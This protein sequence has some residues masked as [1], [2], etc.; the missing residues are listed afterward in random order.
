MTAQETTVAAAAVR[1]GAPAATDAALV[2]AKAAALARAGAHGLPVLPGFVLPTPVVDVLDE[3]PGVIDTA[4][5]RAAWAG[6]SRDGERPLVVRSSSTV[7]DLAGGSMAG[8]FVSV[9]DVRGWEAFVRAVHEVARSRAL[10]G[11]TGGAG[12][13]L[14]V[15]VQPL[16][17]ARVGGVLFGADPVTGRTDRIVVAAVRGQPEPL[18]SGEVD[19]SRL[20]LDLDGRVLSCRS[21]DHGP[22]RREV[23]A[24]RLAALARDTAALYAGPQDVEWAVGSDGRLWLLQSRPVTVALA[25][26]PTGPVLGTG[27][28]AE[29]FPA[30]LTRLEQELWV[31][32]L[33]RAV[34]EAV[35]LAGVAPPAAVA[36]SPA[37][38]CVDGQVAVDLELLGDVRPPSGPAR[39]LDPRPAVRRL[40]AAWRV[41]RLRGALPA[42]G[43]DLVQRVDA[44]LGDVPPL[45]GL[46]DRRLLGLLTRTGE[47]LHSVQAHEMLVGLIVDPGAPRR[48]AASVALR[49]LA[50]ARADGLADPEI[51][52]RHPVVLGLTAP[53]VAA[54][55]AL[56][57]TRARRDA[58]PR[59]ADEPT[60]EP[61]AD[62]QGDAATVRE[63]LRLRARWLHEL[64]ARAAWLLGSR[65]AGRGLLPAPD[66]VRHVGFDDLAR[67]VDGH[68]VALPSYDEGT[69]PAPPPTLPVRFRL[70]DRG[71]PVAVPTGDGDAAEAG[72][73][74]GGGTG[75]GTV[76]DPASLRDGTGPAD[77]VLVVRTLDP[78]LA[79]LLPGLRGLVAE[80]GSVLS[81]L[82]VL[83]R[84]EGVPT[85]VGVPDAAARL[86]PG[87]RVRVDGGSG[88]VTVVERTEEDL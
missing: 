55:P 62:P 22:G 50:T 21:G 84:E 13:P 23:P 24:R 20:E 70:T 85:A 11:D 48:T 39:R 88:R 34:R 87:T 5:V 76:V 12:A 28:V 51:V 83:A 16:L 17:D 37:V 1:L 8:R 75:E 60:P 32:P 56:P 68:R 18:V 73:G 7:E 4:E 64:G 35:A 9:V 45:E 26:T 38:V 40:S 82:A 66:A 57:P 74:A 10:V 25:G 31:P 49:V 81:H 19:G 41:G 36:A 27:P 29:T 3:R 33:R 72:T 80:T 52:T 78:A 53:V 79:P 86:G 2:G 77:P 69:E 46:S 42:L 6:L 63:A 47:A 58:A 54:C 61:V 15:L 67:L 59:A 71:R 30:P 44:E 43:A 14:A 65:L